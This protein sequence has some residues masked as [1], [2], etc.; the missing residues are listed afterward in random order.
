MRSRTSR[1]VPEVKI[2]I[3]EVV[4]RTPGSFGV[5]PVLYRGH[6]KGSGGPPGGSTCPGGPY[7]LYVEGNQPLSG[8]G[9]IPPRA[10]APRVGGN[11]KGGAPLLGGQ[12]PSPWPPP[13]SRS[14]LVGAGPLPPSPI[15]RGARGGLHTTSKAQ[16]LPSP[17]PLLLGKSLAK[18]CRRTASSTTTPSCCR[19]SS[20]TSPSPLLDQGVA[21][22]T[23]P[24]VC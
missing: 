17:T 22:V 15:N 8:L 12:A 7:G 14:H 21:D 5:I 13:P 3:W 11:P 16:P 20:P 2:Y 1:G 10:H 19:S 9:A 24:Y 4:K 23:A 18:P 6:R